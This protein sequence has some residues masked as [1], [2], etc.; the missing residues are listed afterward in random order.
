[1]VGCVI[2][3]NENI[4][5]EGYHKKFGKPHAEINAI[6]SVKNKKTIEG[7]SIY[8]TLEPCSHYGKTPPC[9]DEI[10]NYKPKE[11]IISNK[12]PNPK[13]NGKGIKKL[14]ENNINVI[15][16]INDVIGKELNKRFFLNQKYKM[17]YIILKWAETKDGFIAKTNGESK[18]ISN[19][20]SRTLVHK[21]RSEESGI[22]IG[23][24]TAIKD[25]P[26]L[27]VRR[28]KG[29]NPIRIIIDP[30]N[31]L[32]NTAKVLKEKPITLIYNTTT[33]KKRKSNFFIKI[34]PFSI[35]NIIQDVYKKGISSIMVEGGTKTINYFIDSNLW[36]E[37]RIFVSNKK[38]KKG[39]IAPNLNFENVNKE[40]ING[41]EL[42]IT[43]NNAQFEKTKS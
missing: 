29:K 35:H 2:V 24:Q 16:G 8:I 30:N 31:R 7:S 33:T 6:K 3:K 32:H 19:D 40:D 43:N 27:T 21:W 14:K 23:V 36:H 12:D 9:V 17:P 13:I 37:A 18:W 5:G 25:N 26:K 1:M 28:W 42:H 39:V 34:N 4:I 11:V 22:L 41:D 20:V 38:F 10:I 15:E